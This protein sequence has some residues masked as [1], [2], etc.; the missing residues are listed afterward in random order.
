MEKVFLFAVGYLGH[1]HNMPQE[2]ADDFCL[3]ASFLG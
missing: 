3:V 1:L 2:L